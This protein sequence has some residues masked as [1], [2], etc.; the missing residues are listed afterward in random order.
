MTM[1]TLKSTVPTSTPILTRH[2]QSRIPLLDWPDGESK[3][4]SFIFHINHLDLIGG[5]H[6]F[7]LNTL[8]SMWQWEWLVFLSFSFLHSLTLVSPTYV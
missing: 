8:G 6:F 7:L 3:P 4:T 5:F 2:R 1:A